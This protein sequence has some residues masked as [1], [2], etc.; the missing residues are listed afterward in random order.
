[1]LLMKLRNE[2]KF[3]FLDLA[4]YIANVDGE[5][6]K[7]E[8]DIIEMYC[9]E[10]GIENVQHDINNFNLEETLDKIKTSESQ[11]IAILELMVLAHADDKFHRFEENIACQVANHYNISENKIKTYSQWGKMT[12]AL[13]SQAKLFVEE[14]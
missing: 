10:M 6:E 11:K 2:E 9:A 1:M 5:F 14:I 4:Y 13:Y 8:K 7:E 12:S 3:A